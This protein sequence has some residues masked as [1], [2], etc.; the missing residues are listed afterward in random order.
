[1]SN[2]L[3]Y[4]G[5]EKPKVPNCGCIHVVYDNGEFRLAGNVF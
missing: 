4:F 2:L 5:V 1:M 3:G